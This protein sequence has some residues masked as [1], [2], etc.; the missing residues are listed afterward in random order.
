MLPYTVMSSDFSGKRTGSCLGDDGAN[1]VALPGV[2]VCIFVADSTTKMK[3]Y[4]GPMMF[5]RFDVLSQAAR[6]HNK[7]VAKK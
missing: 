6:G 4:N 1:A 3:I 2:D 7:Y 5:N